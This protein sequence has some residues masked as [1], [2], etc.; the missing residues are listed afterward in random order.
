[1]IN[2]FVMPAL[3]KYKNEIKLDSIVEIVTKYFNT[4]PVTVFSQARYKDMTTPRHLSYYFAIEF[5]N[6]T[7]ID[8]GKFFNRDRTTVIAGHKKIKNFLS[9]KD[10]LTV[11]YVAEI[12]Q[13]LL[14]N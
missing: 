6:C 5:L 11:K 14:G 9:I 1:M 2:Y 8:L 7:G 12:K 3:R 10:E 13:I 4:N